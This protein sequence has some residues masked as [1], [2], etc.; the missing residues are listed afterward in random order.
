MSRSSWSRRQ[1][2]KNDAI[3]FAAHTGIQIGIA[4]P[5]SWLGPL[6]SAIGLA[7]HAFFR[8]ATRTTLNNLA[9]IYPDASPLARRTLARQIFSSLGRNLMDAIALLDPTEAPDRTLGITRESRD[10]LEHA[11][12]EGRGVVYATCHLGPWERMA[13]LLAGLGYP[14]TTIARESY[15]ARFHA[16]IYERLRTARNVEMIY[17]RTFLLPGCLPKARLLVTPCWRPRAR[18]LLLWRTRS[19]LHGSVP[20]PDCGSAWLKR[21]SLSSTHDL[22]AHRPLIFETENGH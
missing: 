10:V 20:A 2:W 1:R 4:L 22:T 3:Y 21:G 14:I 9:H 19:T 17:R 11:L 8:G 16:L 15:D 7:A 18:A 13:A 5:R 6:G 12:G